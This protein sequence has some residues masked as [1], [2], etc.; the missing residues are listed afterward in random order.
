MVACSSVVRAL[1]PVF[2]GFNIAYRSSSGAVIDEVALA[3]EL[4]DYINSVEADK[5]LKV[6]E[7]AAIA[8]RFP[9]VDSIQLP[10]TLR[11]DVPLPN[12]EQEIFSTT[13][14]LS[15]PF[16]PEICLSSSTVGYFCDPRNNITFTKIN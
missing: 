8:Q 14:L 2:V 11:A 15:I 3:Q 1:I 4:S 16:K 6:S 7:I 13:N 12:G 5:E 9:G 10:I